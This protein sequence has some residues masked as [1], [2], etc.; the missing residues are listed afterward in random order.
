MLHGDL[1]EAAVGI[2]RGA[3]AVG[4]GRGRSDAEARTGAGTT[5]DGARPVLRDECAIHRVHG[6]GGVQIDHRAAHRD[7][8][9]PERGER[10]EHGGEARRVFLLQSLSSTFQ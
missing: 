5:H 8:A 10:V 2:E 7:A 3:H 1:A 6:L 9:G 4:K